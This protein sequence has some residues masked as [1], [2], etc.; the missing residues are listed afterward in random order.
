MSKK[1][2]L[3]QRTAFKGIAPQKHKGSA[4]TVSWIGFLDQIRGGYI[5]LFLVL[6]IQGIVFKDFIFLKKLYLFLD[7]G[8]DSYNLFYPA[9]VE[10][11]RYIRTEGI[12]TWSFYSGMGES[13]FPGGLSSPFVWPLYMLGPEKLAYG[14]VF[15]E[16]SKM[17][18]AGI[19]VY[20]YLCILNFSKYT[21]VLGGVLASFLG[22]MVLGST[23]WFGHSTNVVYFFFL[24][25]AFE[26]FYK[27]NVPTL[28]PL[29]VFFVATEPF[30]L[31]LYGVFLFTYALFRMASDTR[32]KHFSMYGSLIFLLKL[33]G[34]GLI[35]VG[36]SAAFSLGSLIEK[37]NS[38]RVIG[39]VRAVS[40]LTSVPVFALPDLQQAA[41]ILL[42]FFSNDIL[43]VGSQYKGYLN[44]LEAPIFYS[45][46]I[47]L[48]LAPQALVGKSRRVQIAFAVFFGVWMVPL[49][50]PFFR[51][52]LYVFMGNYFKH[53]LSIFIP[54][55]MLLYGLNGLETILKQKKIHF[56]ALAT[57]LILLML[58]LH[59][60][61]F[62]EYIEPGQEFVQ[63]QIQTWV[64]CFLTVYSALIFMMRFPNAHEFSKAALMVL[65]CIEL[66]WFSYIT[67][68]HRTTLTREQFTEK[69]GY[70]DYTVEAVSFIKSIDTGFYRI[71]KD[72]S[73]S[74]A[75]VNSINDAKVQ[76][77]FGTP[78]YSSFNS[79]DY[80]DFLQATEIIPKGQ[81]TKTRW[82][83]GLIQ[84]PFLQA[85]ASVKYNLLKNE[86]YERRDVFFK[87]IYEKLADF[88]DV[89]VLKN[90]FFLPLGFTYDQYILRKD[91]ESLSRPHK[92]MA[93]F[94][95]AVMDEDTPPLHPVLAS[96][97]TVQLKNYK[98]SDFSQIVDEKK[99]QALTITSFTQKKI[100][101]KI[102]VTSPKMLFFSI[103]F[104][105]G[106]HASV[107]GSPAKLIKANIGFMGL[108]LTPGDYEVEL[109]Y[110]V[111]HLQATAPISVFFLCVYLLGVMRKMH[112]T[113]LCFSLFS[114]TP[115]SRFQQK[116]NNII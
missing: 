54:A 64:V 19:F 53:G 37:I 8:S 84:R 31:Y 11:A 94:C 20:L 90:N 52:A 112:P 36:M 70:K 33:G 71:N 24:L 39:D 5:F 102:M 7:I 114:P 105:T 42:R 85:V 104:D 111:D 60:P 89:T 6:V 25:Y 48:M 44:Y 32:D 46:L 63:K 65:V 108:L 67:V 35:G 107:N 81:E 3:S 99:N 14:I 40:T 51:Y 93:M 61:Y 100:K 17:L 113:C 75:E 62:K 10:C 91:Y 30:R 59:F 88:G 77:Y 57:T 86:D 109:T 106:W 116:K 4:L 34:L 68:N 23:G 45:G 101:G 92:D 2:K 50:F 47:S 43:G 38:P 41:S 26:L 103:P 22:Y 83:I 9:F 73:S 29:A 96:D 18:L 97:I 95:A 110:R 69:I 13:I 56:G 16:L 80:I 49:V 21:A 1:K 28:F 98:L 76:G 12:P 55:I 78:S 115:K 27:K 15:V 58:I 82:A 66:T 87:M 79:N 74:L 72:Y